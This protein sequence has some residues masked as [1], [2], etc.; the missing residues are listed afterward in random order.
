[1]T[2]DTIKSKLRL[3]GL[4]VTD[5]RM[6]LFRILEKSGC[7]PQTADEIRKISKLDKVTVYRTL[8]SFVDAGFVQQVE[9]RDGVA[10]YEIKHAHHHHVVCTKC[11]L[12]ADVEDCM[13]EAG[14]KSLEK[15][16]GFSIAS[17]ALEF[18]GICRKC[19]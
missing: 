6:M 4:K 19:Q 15:K 18:F 16:T 3:N 13:E 7:N 14:V 9:F 8:E 1:M 12:V 10:R 5:P 11:G 17:H 2:P